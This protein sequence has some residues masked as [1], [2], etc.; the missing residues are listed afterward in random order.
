MKQISFQGHKGEQTLWLLAGSS[1]KQD[2]LDWHP[3]GIWASLRFR[4]WRLEVGGWSLELGALRAFSTSELLLDLRINFQLLSWH[5][6]M[7]EWPWQSG[8]N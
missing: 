8:V 3:L 5:Q 2:I 1:V 6:S 4:A 7:A